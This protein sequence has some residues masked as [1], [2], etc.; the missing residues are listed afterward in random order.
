MLESLGETD[1]LNPT[2]PTSQ[3][4]RSSIHMDPRFS[5]R[6]YDEFGSLMTLIGL[7]SINFT[8]IM[9]SQ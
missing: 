6:F 3:A 5:S 7:L 8:L 9:G 2:E 1:R 4:T